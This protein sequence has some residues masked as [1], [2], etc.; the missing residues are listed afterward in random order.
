M[1][2]IGTIAASLSEAP[3][4]GM[5]YYLRLAT[6]HLRFGSIISAN[7][8]TNMLQS[9]ANSGDEIPKASTVG[10]IRARVNH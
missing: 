5:R 1:E 7:C 9:Q 3:T 2:E 6:Y 10:V 8:W 4:F